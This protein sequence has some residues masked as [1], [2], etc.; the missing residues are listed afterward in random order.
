MGNLDRVKRTVEER[1]RQLGDDHPDTVH[2][3]VDLAYAYRAMLDRR[4]A[5][6][7]QKEVVSTRRDVLGAEHDDT[8]R[9]EAVLV[10]D[11]YESNE[12]EDAREIQERL[13]H[14]WERNLE[15]D[16]E[17]IELALIAL[18]R[19][20]K[21]LGQYDGF[22]D[23]QER[24]LVLNKRVKGEEHPDTLHAMDELA[25]A[26]LVL[27]DCVSALQL[28]STLVD[29]YSRELGADESTTLRIRSRVAGELMRTGKLAEA[30]IAIGAVVEAARHTLA[31]SDRLRAGI[32]QAAVQIRSVHERFG[33]ELTEEQLS[34]LLG[35]AN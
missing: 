20:L 18:A 31:P 28:D 9:A 14:I 22:S 16:A 26:R 32:E 25:F 2:A 33:D 12:L 4:S 1:P 27:G 7:V 19:T 3:L 10:I 6:D 35:L 24:L 5:I 11:L 34:K 23:L 13:V 17:L 29:I 8:L 21:T 15:P 30:S